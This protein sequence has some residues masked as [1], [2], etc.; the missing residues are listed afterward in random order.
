MDWTLSYLEV[1]KSRMQRETQWD[2]L[3]PWAL[4]SFSIIE[5]TSVKRKIFCQSSLRVKRGSVVQL[6][7][8]SF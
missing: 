7:G 8:K 3:F 1:R 4:E 5:G 6:K 2:W